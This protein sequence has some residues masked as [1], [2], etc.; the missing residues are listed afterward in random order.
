VHIVPFP[1][2]RASRRTSTLTEL[3]VP[4]LTLGAAIDRFE[5]HRRPRV[6]DGTLRTYRNRLTVWLTWREQRGYSP[7]LREIPI[8]EFRAFLVY[9][10]EEHIAYQ[11]TPT[12]RRPKRLEPASIDGTYRVLQTFW[13]FLDQD[14]LLTDAQARFFQGDRLSRP[15]VPDD[16]RPVYSEDDLEQLLAAF[17]E[18]TTP[19]EVARNRAMLL[20]L[21]ESGARIN[22][23]CT[24]EEERVDLAERTGVVFGKGRK[25]RSI[26]WTRRTAA[27]LD[28]YLAV[29]RGPRGGP[30][31]RSCG[32]DPAVAA[33]LADSFRSAVKR[34]AKRAGLKLFA[35]A[36]VHAFRHAFARRFLDAGGE[37][38][39]LQQLLGHASMRTTERYV[40][41]NPNTLRK[42][43]RR[44][45]GD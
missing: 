14:D 17:A 30:L 13:N 28:D 16:P 9:L 12:R 5:E 40:R 31:F 35:G 22:E 32:N 39:H 3:D 36:P 25:Y 34:S 7:I 23:V 2:T 26:F 11:S 21:Y 18:A 6:T 41:E 33:I 15:V 19:E 1:T 20:V 29:R 44:I 43:Y 8:E 45:F 10:T 38:L 42:I 27:A 37:G 4:A 24:L